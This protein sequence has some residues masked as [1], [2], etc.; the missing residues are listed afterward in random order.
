MGELPVLNISFPCCLSLWMQAIKV[1]RPLLVM[2]VE[3]AGPSCKM[4]PT[5]GLAH[6]L[7]GPGIFPSPQGHQNKKHTC[8]YYQL[9]DSKIASSRRRV[10]NSTHLMFRDWSE[11]HH[12]YKTTEESSRAVSLWVCTTLEIFVSP[13]EDADVIVYGLNL[14]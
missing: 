13:P 1:M 8:F 11:L 14:F 6:S 4:T 2:L 12:L 7:N 5:L 3:M 9:C 10:R